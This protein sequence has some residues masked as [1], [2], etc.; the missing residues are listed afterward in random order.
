MD[1]IW[2]K[3]LREENFFGPLTVGD[4]YL[5]EEPAWLDEDDQPQLTTAGAPK[6]RPG[7][8]TGEAVVL[9]VGGRERTPALLRVAGDPYETS[10]NY[11][12]WA[13]DA[14][15]IATSGGTLDELGIPHGMVNRRVR[16]RLT[17]EQAR[18]VRRAFG[19]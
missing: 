1:A 19:V 14:E 8:T 9:Y 2:M 5:L 7:W 15:V 4:A 12:P 10:K 17:D 18:R 13:T 11:W 16:W 6:G 3:T